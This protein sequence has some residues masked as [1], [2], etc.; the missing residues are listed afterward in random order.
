MKISFRVYF[1]NFCI[2]NTYW[3]PKVT[4]LK[5][6]C[7]SLQSIVAITPSLQDIFEITKRYASLAIGNLRNFLSIARGYDGS[8]V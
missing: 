8:R 2:K 6:F 5:F 3:E 4:W 1:E 7:V